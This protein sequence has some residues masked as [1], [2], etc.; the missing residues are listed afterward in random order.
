[1]FFVLAKVFWFLLQ[2]SSLMVGAVIA[3]AA[4]MGT[5]WQRLA[6]RLI[7]GAVIALLICGLSPISDA[8]I[9]PLEERF[10][11]ADLERDGKAITGIIVLGGGED[12]RIV[13]R[14]ELAP[15]NEAAERYTEGVALARRL[16]QARLIFSGG[17]GVLV[18]AHQVEADMAQRLFVALG[19][20][21]DRIALESKSRD[22]YENA[23]LTASMVKPQPGERWL[24]VTSAVHMPRAMGC[25]RRAGFAVEAWPVDYRTSRRLEWVRWP[26][27]IADGLKRI[28]AVTREYVGLV[29]YYLAGRTDALLPGPRAVQ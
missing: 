19:V 14:P 24:L 27:S 1:V 7:W 9:Q 4:L 8:M 17:S 20:A 12:S 3:G 21:A 22:T 23:A 16:P 11:R 5:V 26:G 10:G 25:F 29:M 2:P 13:G 18:G 28:D 6:R 15:L